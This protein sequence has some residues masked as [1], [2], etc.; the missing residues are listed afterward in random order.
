MALNHTNE[1]LNLE[2]Q[3]LYTERGQSMEDINPEPPLVTLA[4]E[5]GIWRCQVI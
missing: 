1:G 2:P 3:S 5:S 4:R